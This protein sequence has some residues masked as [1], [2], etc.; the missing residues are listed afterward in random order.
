MEIED[1]RTLYTYNLKFVPTVIDSLKQVEW[2]R[3]ANEKICG[4]GS[5]RNLSVHTSG[6]EEYWFSKVLQGRQYE[7]FCEDCGKPD[8]RRQKQVENSV[9]TYNEVNIWLMLIRQVLK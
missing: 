1:Y 6:A 2:D 9:F 7:H 4:W 3:F 8:R 5:V